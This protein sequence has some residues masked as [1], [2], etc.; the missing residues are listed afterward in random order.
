MTTGDIMILV[1]KRGLSISYRMGHSVGNQ[2]LVP[3]NRN[4]TRR[5]D[6]CQWG[7]RKPCVAIK[8]DSAYLRL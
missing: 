7:K 5:W 2:I 6:I 1:D 3:C 8:D 4:M